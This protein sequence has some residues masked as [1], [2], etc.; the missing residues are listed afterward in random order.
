MRLAWWVA[1]FAA[2]TG[3]EQRLRLIEMDARE[4]QASAVTPSQP[5]ESAKGIE[6]RV[7][8][9]QDEFGLERKYEPADGQRGVTDGE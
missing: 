9:I 1:P 6:R 4:I 3:L 7:N 8:A 2:K 5:D